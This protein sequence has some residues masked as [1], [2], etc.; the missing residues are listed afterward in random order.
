MYAHTKGRGF[1]LRAYVQVQGE[2]VLKLQNLSVRTLW[3]TPQKYFHYITF[4]SWY[5]NIFLFKQNKFEGIF[6]YITFFIIYK[7]IYLCIFLSLIKQDFSD[8][9][10]FSFNPAL[11]SIFGLPF[12]FIKVRVLLSVC[13]FISSTRVETRIMEYF[14]MKVK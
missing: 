5:Q 13:K 7:E 12:V 6:Y 4:F 8:C 14:V 11:V 9:V 10:N 1:K 2:G 3:I